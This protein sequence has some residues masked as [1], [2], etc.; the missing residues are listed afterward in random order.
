M[1]ACGKN[2]KPQGETRLR[3]IITCVGQ[4]LH[5]SRATVTVAL[6]IHPQEAR[7]KQGL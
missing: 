2:Q 1:I 7:S 6:T 3:L 5:L 4:V